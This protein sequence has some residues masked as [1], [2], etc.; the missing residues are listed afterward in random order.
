L[1]SKLL[2]VKSLTQS[3]KHRWTRLVYI[4]GS[5]REGRWARSAVKVGCEIDSYGHEILHLLALHAALQL[6][7]L[8]LV[9][10]VRMRFSY[11]FRGLLLLLV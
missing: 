10:P 3:L 1:P 6:A 11:Y 8:G 7:L 5:V 2:D 4:C 9:Q